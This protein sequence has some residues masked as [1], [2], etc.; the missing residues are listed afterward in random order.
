[1]KTILTTEQ[2]NTEMYRK[3][4]IAEWREKCLVLGTD[5]F[6]VEAC[7]RRGEETALT[8][9]VKLPFPYFATLYFNSFQSAD[10][11]TSDPAFGYKLYML[12]NAEIKLFSETI[13]KGKCINR[14]PRDYSIRI[15][16]VEI[17]SSLK[18]DLESFLTKP[19]TNS[20]LKEQEIKFAYISQY[21]DTKV[22]EQLNLKIVP[23]LE[24]E[25]DLGGYNI[26]AKLDLLNPIARIIVA[27]TMGMYG[28]DR[29]TK[30]KLSQILN[31][32]TDKIRYFVN[33]IFPLMQKTL[34]EAKNKL[35]PIGSHEFSMQEYNNRDYRFKDIEIECLYYL[36]CCATPAE[37]TILSGLSNDKMKLYIVSKHFGWTEEQVCRN[38][39]V[40]SDDIERVH[41]MAEK[42]E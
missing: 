39:T 2:E 27:R 41:K 38:M 24:A 42:K 19:S 1:M 20:T 29:T 21:I 17:A 25:E 32:P 16:F 33:T 8:N 11:Y 37:K 36:N 30:T 22:A 40:V 12:K 3:Y 23:F 9:I 18:R 6:E 26:E 35:K 28:Y 10:G 5:A 13:K 14:K 7:L 15:S 4:G 34:G 31:L